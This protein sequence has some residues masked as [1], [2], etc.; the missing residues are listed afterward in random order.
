[1]PRHVRLDKVIVPVKSIKL[2]KRLLNENPVLKKI[3]AHS[4]THEDAKKKIK[5]WVL[6]TIKDKKAVYQFYRDIPEPDFNINALDW[7]DIAAIRILDYIDHAGVDIENPNFKDVLTEND[8]FKLLWLAIH[9]GTGGARPDFF[10]DMIHLFRQFNGKEKRE[11]PAREEIEEWMELYPSGLEPQIIQL[12]EKNKRRILKIIIAKMD[13]GEISD[14]KYFFELGLTEEEKLKTAF[15][16]WKETSFHLKFAVRNP[17]LLDELLN[18][19]LDPIT[20]EVLHDAEEKGIPFFIN[21]YYLSLLNVNAPWFA[22][23]AE[24]AIR[25]YVIYSKEL[26]ENFGSITAW[27][28]EDTV[29]PGK[30]NAAGW[31]LPSRNNVHRRYPEVAILIPDTTGRACGGLCSSCQR[32]YNFQNGILNFNLD[33]LKPDESWSVR[34]EKYMQY[35]EKDAQLR[36]ILITGGDAFMNSN[37]SLKKILEAVYNMAVRKIKAN[38]KRPDGE[39]FAEIQ[40][41]RLGTRI[42]VYLPQR[43]NPELISILKEFREKA[44]KIGIC[45]FVI[46]THFISPMEITPEAQKA[47][48]RILSAGW[49]VTNQHVYIT[50]ASRRG[51]GA[52]LRKVLN[53][54]GILPYYSFS[55][56]GHNENLYNFATNA[57]LI[58]EQNEEKYIGMIPEEY[59]EKIKNFAFDPPRMVENIIGLKEK[60]QLPFLSTDKSV[61]NMPGVGKSMSFRTIGITR[62]GR[63]ILQFDHDPSR[64]HSPIINKMG[65]VIIVESKAINDYLHQLS[66]MG[67]DISDYKSIWG[68]SIGQSEK[69]H[70][71]YEYPDYDFKITEQY[72]NIQI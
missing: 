44:V 52:K 18:H 56:K 31:I 67:E 23:G 26:V 37:R 15:E 34:L 33:E 5:K 45:Q 13:E 66:N 57:R 51:H 25:D 63:R 36:D 35:F 72:S 59:H 1:M 7:N 71:L 54:I 69:R 65:K 9:R 14:P 38:K 21:L 49:I 29:E 46:Q 41:V 19:S 61:L 53:D 16:W 64:L 12:R 58:Q 42:P 40:R 24:L 60:L 43:I 50:A 3:M 10:D 8:P 27:E 2:L 20:M 30:P 32:M 70:S 22:V 55:V 39:K 6:D 68:Y 62:R 47:V 4:P 17:D 11:I 48:Q 28:K